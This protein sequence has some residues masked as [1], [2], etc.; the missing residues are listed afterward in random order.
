M[1]VAARVFNAGVFP[2]RDVRVRLSL[3]GRP[4]IEQTSDARRSFAPARP[5][6]SADQASRACITVFVEVA[7]GDDLPF[8]DRRWLA[9]EAR[10]PDRVLLVDGEPGPSVFG[11]ETYYLETALRLR[12][13]G[14]RLERHS[15]RPTSRPALPGAAGKAL[16]PT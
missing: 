5:I 3:E 13:P 4:P 14:R 9:F 16:C 8:D 11:N 1:T 12:L 2:A 7:G 15:R 6:R 10:R